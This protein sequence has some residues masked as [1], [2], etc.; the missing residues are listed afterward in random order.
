MLVRL[1]FN[2]A[3]PSF[4]SAPVG[5][6]DVIFT[7]REPAMVIAL[8]L[9]E[10]FGCVLVKKVPSHICFA[11]CQTH[12]YSTRVQHSHGHT[13]TIHC[14]GHDSFLNV[15]PDR[16]SASQHGTCLT[17]GHGGRPG[18]DLSN[19]DPHALTNPNLK[20]SPPRSC[21]TGRWQQCATGSKISSPCVGP[22]ALAG[23]SRCERFWLGGQVVRSRLTPGVGDQ[24]RVNGQA[25]RLETCVQERTKA[26]LLHSF[27]LPPTRGSGGGTPG[28]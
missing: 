6:I 13:S 10:L 4:T 21:L 17:S 18:M 24:A 25:Q 3:E 27:Q 11:H 16:D 26:E 20:R 15:M 12:T 19:L 2:A 22:R 7:H 23:P 1:A 8:V 28:Q 9:V 14:Q 5:L